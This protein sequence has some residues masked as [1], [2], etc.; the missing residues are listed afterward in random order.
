MFKRIIISFNIL[1]FSKI[2][3]SSSMQN[4][5]KY[6][7]HSDNY[8]LSFLEVLDKTTCATVLD[9]LAPRGPIPEM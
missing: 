8:S 6:E 5:P 4:S 3:Y 9:N 2:W 1:K 7:V